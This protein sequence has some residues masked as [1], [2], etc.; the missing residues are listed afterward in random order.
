MI[1]TVIVFWKRKPDTKISRDKTDEF[2]D[3]KLYILFVVKIMV[4]KVVSKQNRCTKT[5]LLLVLLYFIPKMDKHIG[6]LLP[7]GSYLAF[8]AFWSSFMQSF[9]YMVILLGTST[10]LLSTIL[11]MFVPES[12]SLSHSPLYTLSSTSEIL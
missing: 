1:L 10:K 12:Y 7:L 2:L 9:P 5:I 3:S 6:K 4:V 8:P 11:L